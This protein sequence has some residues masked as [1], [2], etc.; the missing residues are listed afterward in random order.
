M[1]EAGKKILIETKCLGETPEISVECLRET[2][3][4]TIMEKAIET[5]F[6]VNIY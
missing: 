5:S 3:I 2:S 6:Y 4:E 1:V